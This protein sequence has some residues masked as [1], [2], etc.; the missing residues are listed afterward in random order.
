ME[1]SDPAISVLAEG[2]YKNPFVFYLGLFTPVKVYSNYDVQKLDIILK[3][4]GNQGYSY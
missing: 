1:V 4:K 2:L 3:I